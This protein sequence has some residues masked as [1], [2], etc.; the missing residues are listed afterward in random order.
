MVNIEA[1]KMVKL[2]ANLESDNIIRDKVNA[3]LEAA[4]DQPVFKESKG[5][6]NLS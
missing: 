3:N 5:L 1:E 2:N 4:E 6:N